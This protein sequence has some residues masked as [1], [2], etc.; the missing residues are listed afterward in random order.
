MPLQRARFDSGLCEFLGRAGCR[1]KPLH[2]VALP[3]GGFADRCQRSGLACASK[4][5]QGRDLI[6]ACEY[7]LDRCTLALTQMGMVFLGLPAGIEANEGRVLIL[8]SAH[9]SDRVALVFNHLL[10]GKRSAWRVCFPFYFD[11]ITCLNALLKL[12][13]DLFECRLSHRTPQCVSQQFAFFD[14]SLPLQVSL[15][16]EGHGRLCA[17]ARS[18]LLNSLC[19]LPRCC[20]H[21][22]W[23]VSK[24]FRHLLMALLH[25][26]L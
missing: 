7:L 9:G 10:R 24:G 22:L 2:L 21:S 11:E 20:C 4:A 14:D 15:F 3:L 26:F 1:G 19:P 12:S 16:R 8:A 5:F 18:I 6:P 13:F 23:L 17:Y 25:F